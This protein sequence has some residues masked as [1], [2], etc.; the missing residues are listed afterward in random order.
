MMVLL[1][2]FICWDNVHPLVQAALTLRSHPEQVFIEAASYKVVNETV[3]G[4]NNLKTCFVRALEVD[5]AQAYLL[6][7]SSSSYTPSIGS[8]IRVGKGTY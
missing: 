6:G 4:F 5:E 1:K 3:C 7:G 2:I 8:L